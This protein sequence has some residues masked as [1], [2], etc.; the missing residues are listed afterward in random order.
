MSNASGDFPEWFEEVKGI[1]TKFQLGRGTGLELRLRVW[2]DPIHPVQPW[3]WEVVETSEDVPSEFE[4][5]VG[6]AESR[7]AAIEAAIAR[8][9][10]Y[11]ETGE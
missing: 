7:E 3:T 9:A 8:A 6:G 5:D 2:A 11:L 4:V 10:A 1:W